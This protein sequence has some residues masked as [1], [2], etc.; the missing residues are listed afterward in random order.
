MLQLHGD[1][2]FANWQQV[3]AQILAKPFPPQTSDFPPQTLEQ[4]RHLSFKNY[5]NWE[6]VCQ[7]ILD[8]EFSHVYYQ[9]C[10]DELRQRGKTEQDIFEMRSV[11]WHTVGWF[12]YPMMVWDWTN[13]DESDIHRAITWLLAEKQISPEKSQEFTDFVARHAD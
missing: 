7:E 12:N 4:D 10:H 3:C 9:R 2:L 1:Q 11:A 6:L 5:S 13:L 8:T